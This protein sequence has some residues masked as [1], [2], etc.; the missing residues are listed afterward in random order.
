MA[1]LPWVAIGLGVAVVCANWEKW[2]KVN[3]K[4][5]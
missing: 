4:N 5:H 1:A 2:F 3:N